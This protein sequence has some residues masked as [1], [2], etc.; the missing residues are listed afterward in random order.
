MGKVGS[1][2]VAAS[3][4]RTLRQPVFHVHRMNPANIKNVRAAYLKKELK[5][6]NESTGY[7]LHKVVN[8]NRRKSKIITLVR[9]PIG[10]NI[11][12]F[13]ENYHT[14]TD[15]DYTGSNVSL[16]DLI[17]LFIT[18]YNHDVPL[19]W[20]DIEMKSVT[21]IDVFNFPFPKKT[22]YQVISESTHQLL[23]LKL[24]APDEVKEKAISEFLNISDFRL[25][26]RNVGSNKDYATTYSRFKNAIDLPKSYLD[27]MLTSKFTTHF[28]SEDEIVKI[29]KRWTKVGHRSV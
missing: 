21:G 15:I 23:I 1:K 5:P 29:R 25:L 11:S 16:P 18:S 17:Q 20:F 24:E 14:F 8:R 28:Y 27:K 12:A 3:L 26:R 6:P 13:F 7:F 10:R 19:R 2:S 9:E 22:G 4:R